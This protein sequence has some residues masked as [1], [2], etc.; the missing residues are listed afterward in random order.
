MKMKGVSLLIL[1]ALLGITVPAAHAEV[2]DVS[3]IGFTSKHTL[4]IAADRN[5]VYTALTA[6]VGR[7]W[8]ERHSFGGSAKA[9]SIDPRPGGCFCE[10][11]PG[12]G[13]VHM[14]VVFADP[15][16]Q[17]RMRGELGPLQTMAVTGSM[18]FVLEDAEG[19]TTTLRYVYAVGGYHADGLAGI[20]A[21]VDLVQLGQLQ[22]LKRFIE[23]GSPEPVKST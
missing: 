10:A 19:G 12:G 14:V 21:A 1:G 4:T 16:R 9:F 15:G 6:E 22:R 23:T 5:R 8:D 17:L 2:T 11:L 13:V 7:W 20:S 18:Q 3:D